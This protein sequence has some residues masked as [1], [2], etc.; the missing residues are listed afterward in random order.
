MP[1]SFF[2]VFF[3]L[4]LFFKMLE[5]AGRANNSVPDVS[6]LIRVLSATSAKEENY[7]STSASRIR[8]LIDFSKERSNRAEALR[9]ASFISERWSK[10]G[11]E[12]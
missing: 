2:F 5:Q 1:C 4:F 6:E 8:D 9:A 7:G 10:R 12:L 3:A 11:V